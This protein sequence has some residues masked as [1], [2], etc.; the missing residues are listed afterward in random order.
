MMPVTLTDTQN[1]TNVVV[2][3]GQTVVIKLKET[4]TTGYRW[5]LQVPEADAVKVT[6]SNWQPAPDAEIG[7]AGWRVFCLL[8]RRKGSIQITL[9]LY[10]EWEGAE[11]A[12]DSRN[13]TLDAR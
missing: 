9:K 7:A 6:D 1:G 12:I 10:R 8:I 11:A 4:P 3:V 2:E 13:F 5:T